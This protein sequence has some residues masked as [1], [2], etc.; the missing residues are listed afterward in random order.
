MNPRIGVDVDHEHD[1]R[2]WVY[3]LSTRYV[4]A[5]VDAGGIPVLVTPADPRP[6]SEI[7]ASVDGW[8]MT[9]GD[10][11]HPS[12]LGQRAE[13]RPMRLLSVHRERFVLAL[14]RAV[15]EQDT[16]CLAVCLGSQALNTA[17]GG[18][19]W[20][21]LSSEC[22]VERDG[23]EHKGGAIHAVTPEPGGL[24]SRSWQGTT[25]NLMSHHHQAARRLAPGLRLEARAEDG[26][27]EAFSA[28]EHPFLLAVQWHPE[29]QDDRPGGADLV[30]ALVRAAAARVDSVPEA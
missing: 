30:A 5:I 4:E 19:L 29:V 24:L 3:K 7:V 28:P 14:A 18:E 1:G 11:F 23:I 9:G 22:G 16:P 2:R 26:V 21:D 10:D 8:L 12:L 6:M 20:F 17:L 27:I 25:R 15:L 13:G